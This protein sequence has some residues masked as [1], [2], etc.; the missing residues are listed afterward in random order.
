MKTA[1]TKALNRAIIIWLIPALYLSA[2]SI[3]KYGL[4]NPTWLVP[5][6]GN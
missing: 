4:D 5:T 3:F 1:L 2:Y 6:G